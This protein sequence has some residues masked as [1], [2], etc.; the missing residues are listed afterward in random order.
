[1]AQPTSKLCSYGFQFRNWPGAG[2]K[3][4]AQFGL[5]HAV[6]VPPNA[7]TVIIGGQVGIRDDG[8]VPTDLAEEVAE[9]FDHVERSL[10]AAGFGEDAWE[11]VYSVTTYEVEKD[12]RGI[13]NVVVPIAHK[14]LK[15]TK[16]AWSGVTVK[17]LAFP[18]LHIEITV[19]AFLPKGGNGRL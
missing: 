9:A 10:K 8:T 18:E 17:G 14:Y 7:C 12:G 13:A 16:P 2:E 1:M 3:A 11:H 5:S 19:Q 15:N 4:A 6:I